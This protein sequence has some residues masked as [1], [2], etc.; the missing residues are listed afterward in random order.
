MSSFHGLCFSIIN[1][2]D[3]YFSGQTTGKNTN[4]RATDLMDLLGITGRT[5]NDLADGTVD[6]IDWDAVE[7][8][9]CE[10][11]TESLQ[12]LIDSLSDVED[13]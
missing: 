2:R 6:P 8:R 7:A 10:L 12:L 5:V 3:F 9:L 11:R 13:E 4:S 1:H